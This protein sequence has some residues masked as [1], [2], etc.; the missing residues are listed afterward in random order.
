MVGGIIPFLSSCGSDYKLEDYVSSKFNKIMYI[1]DGG[2][3]K[4]IETNVAAASCDDSVMI[5]KAGMNSQATA[6]V[7]VKVLSQAE[8]AEAFSAYSS[9]TVLPTGYYTFT[10]GEELKF[11]SNDRVKSFPISFDLK[12]L[13]AAIL[14]Q[15]N[16]KFALPI[17]IYSDNDTI[18][19]SYDKKLLV[20]DVT[21][22]NLKWG[23]T[24]LEQSMAYT[25]LDVN[26]MATIENYVSTISN[27]T[28]GLDVSDAA[29][30]VSAYNSAHNT[31]YELLPAASYTFNNF[32]F[33]S[34][35]STAKMTINRSGLQGDHDY[36]LP[37]KFKSTSSQ[38]EA[39]DV[40]YLIV[41]NPKYGYIL[42]DR[43]SWKIVFCND[44]NK[45][46]DSGSPIPSVDD[47]DHKG[48]PAILD[49]NISTYWMY[50]SD[51][52][53]WWNINGGDD[54]DYGFKDYNAFYGDRALRDGHGGKQIII[55]DMQQV[56]RISGIGLVQRQDLAKALVKADFFVSTDNSFKF[57]PVQSGG[58]LSDY[59]E[60]GLNNWSSLFTWNDI[61]VQKAI[62]WH[63][64]TT[65]QLANGGV[66]GRF[67]KIVIIEAAAGSKL[68]GACI[69]EV[70]VQ[71]LVTIDGKAVD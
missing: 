50:G 56:R 43:S 18:N 37:L 45:F 7:K 20:L 40:Q 19:T 60:A 38:V 57:T 13:S 52:D 29:S 53:W 42:P 21:V 17:Q 27:F 22:P 61:P 10:N 5:G 62:S 63:Q 8:M 58:N 66:K 64:V 44:D 14:A 49:D 71:Q 69:A 59:N 65:D 16:A 55:I 68:H 1:R 9:Y 23:T 34:A 15:P 48:A 31:S 70:K 36:I 26:L 30:L 3:A 35:S 39:T 24:N 67:L 12:K 54:Y 33:S 47:A 11:N 25:T 6:D 2:T 51:N 4:V 46:A 32:S 28:C 41:H